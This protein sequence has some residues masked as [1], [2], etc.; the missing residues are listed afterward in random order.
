MKRIT[1]G[2]IEI[3][4]PK[5]MGTPTKHIRGLQVILTW[6]RE[7]ARVIIENGKIKSVI[8]KFGQT[9]NITKK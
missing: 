6:P 8:V 1:I 9:C 3:R 7:I 5:S 4:W 2:A